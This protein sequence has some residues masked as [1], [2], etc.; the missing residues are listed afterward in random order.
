M[1]TH[2]IKSSSNSKAENYMN[3]VQLKENNYKYLGDT[4]SKDGSS[5]IATAT[6]PTLDIWHS[7]T[8][9]FATMFKL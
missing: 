9:R 2:E 8:I 5:I 3:E 1:N 7:N 4:L 6:M